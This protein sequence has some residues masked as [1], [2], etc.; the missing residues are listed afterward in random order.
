MQIDIMS[1]TGRGIRLSEKIR[2]EILVEQ[3]DYE[4]HLY[5]KYGKYQNL[6]DAERKIWQKQEQNAAGWKNQVYVKETIYDWMRA[7]FEQNRKGNKTAVIWIGA[8][9]IA[10]RAMAPSLRDKLTD[11]P[12]LVVDEAG[13]FVIPVL[14]GHY[15]GANNLARLLADRI[16]AVPVIT[17]ATDVNHAFAVD[18]FAKENVL[19]IQNKAQIAAVSSKVLDGKKIVMLTDGKIEGNVPDSVIL[20]AMKICEEENLIVP[21]VIISARY[22]VKKLLL[23]QVMD[24]QLEVKAH[25][26]PLWLVPRS[27]ILG[28]GCKRGKSCEEIEQFVLETLEQ[29]QIAIQAVNALATIDLKKEEP[30]FLQFA[31]KYGLDFLAYPKEVLKEIPGFFSSSEFVSQTVGVDNVCERAALAA[32]QKEEPKVCCDSSENQKK[33]LSR[34]RL[35]LRKKAKDGMTLAIAEREWSVR[36]DET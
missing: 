19:L 28:M 33:V 29:E 6:A 4:V 32:C 36:F 23:N 20:S 1:F 22:P 26:E 13:Q 5:T 25:T 2:D 15:G 16:G 27:I 24:E 21:D 8:C 18:V 7:R 31:E 34:G 11:I 3:E 9:G 10:V 14:S 35:L 12:V 30:G 17:T